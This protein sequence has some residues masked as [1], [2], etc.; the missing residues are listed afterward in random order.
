MK[1]FRAF[2]RLV[3]LIVAE[4]MMPCRYDTQMIPHWQQVADRVQLLAAMEGLP[5]SWILTACQSYLW[6]SA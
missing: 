4:S 1:D 6:A 5:D 3:N 2:D